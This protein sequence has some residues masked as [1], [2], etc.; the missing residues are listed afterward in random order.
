MPASDD[1]MT[2]VQKRSGLLGA[3]GPG[4]L[5]A[6]TGVGAGDLAAA[7]LAGQRLGVAIAWAVVVG[8]LFKYVLTEALSRWQLSTGTTVLEGSGVVLGRW[9]TGLFLIYLIPWC[10]VVGAALLSAAGAATQ[11]LI[12]LPLEPDAARVVWG[13]VISVLALATV[14]V[15]GYRIFERVMAVCIGVMTVAVLIT[16]ATVDID[17]TQAARGLFLPSIPDHPEGVIWTMGLIG[18]VGGTVTLLCYGYWIRQRGRTGVQSIG[19]CRID[20]AAGYLLTAVFGVAMLFIASVLEPGSG[21]TGVGLLEGIARRLDGALGPWA[22]WLFLIGAWSAI[23]S[24]V[25]GVWQSVPIIVADTWR[26][27]RGR[28]P[29]GADDLERL[30][31]TRV[32]MVLLATIPLVQVAAPFAHVQKLYT[33]TGAFFLPLLALALLLLTLRRSHMGVHR[34]GGL[35]TVSLCVVL[36]FFIWIVV[37]KLA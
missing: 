24:S 1:Q 3:I 22:F 19:T 20:L 29:M 15:G 27:L 23:V 7:S 36:G 21:E 34:S 5:V 37:Q 4:L 11:A 8:A 32:V 31:S 35:G 26:T 33:V 2:N 12:P 30:G 25:L 9:V 28:S 6:A 10:W 16:A 14:W 18:G 17:W 13:G